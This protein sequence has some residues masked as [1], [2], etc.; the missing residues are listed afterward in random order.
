MN[1]NIFFFYGQF[2]L[3]MCVYVLIHYIRLFVIPWTV[4]HQAPLSIGFSRQEYWSG[5]ACS[6]P[7]AL[8]H[9]GTEPASFTSPALSGRF[10]T[11]STTTW[12]APLLSMV[13]PNCAHIFFVFCCSRRCLSRCKHCSKGAQVPACLTSFLQRDLGDASLSLSMC[14]Y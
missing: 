9:L 14:E 6:L 8:P 4:A 7:G 3:C 2:S 13:F 1:E 12:E 11:A 10:F 5:L